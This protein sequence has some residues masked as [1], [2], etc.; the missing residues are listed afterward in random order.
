MG[1]GFA[2]AGQIGARLLDV[3]Y[4]KLKARYNSPGRPEFR[5]PFQ[6]PAA[7][8]MPLGLLLY[9]WGAQKAFHWIVPDIG[10]FLVSFAMILVFNSSQ[11]YLLD[12]FT[13]YSAS[14]VAATV[15][16]R[17]LFGFALPLAAP[18]MWSSL[19]YGW[20]CTLLAGLAILISWPSV[21]LRFFSTDDPQCSLSRLPQVPVLWFY[22]ERIRMRSK[23]A[24]KDT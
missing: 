7:I 11:M 1:L 5:L 14:A 21:S 8:L 22:G 2:A 6:F 10:L 17:S 24:R 23:F 20:G 9:G 16:L 4:R 3:M 12:T 18:Y 13:M 15:C 19:G